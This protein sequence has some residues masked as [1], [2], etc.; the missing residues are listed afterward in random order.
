MLEGKYD[1][2]VRVLDLRRKSWD[3]AMTQNAP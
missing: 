3:A 1:T 2:G